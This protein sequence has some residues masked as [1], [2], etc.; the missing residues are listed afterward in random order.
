MINKRSGLW[1][2]WNVSA[3][4][5]AKSVASAVTHLC[6]RVCFCHHFSFFYWTSSHFPWAYLSEWCELQWAQT[7]GNYTAVAMNKKWIKRN[8]ESAVRG[9]KPSVWTEKERH[10]EGKKKDRKWK[11]EK[12]VGYPQRK[13]LFDSVAAKLLT[14]GKRLPDRWKRA[15][16]SLYAAT[17]TKTRKA[18]SQ[19]G[20]TPCHSG[21]RYPCYIWTP[22]SH[23]FW[24]SAAH[25]PAGCLPVKM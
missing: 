24:W 7:A 5:D 20:K 8:T 19:T 12:G 21:T 4:T 11:W 17:V 23:S 15:S 3:S 6:K 14:A 1:S 13:C 10:R 16:K 9:L 22:S 18:K 2:S 25:I